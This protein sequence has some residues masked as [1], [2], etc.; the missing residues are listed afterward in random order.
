MTKSKY[1][2]KNITLLNILLMGAIILTGHYSVLP[3]L[4]IN[5][6]YTLPPLKK[7]T[8]EEEMMTSA[9]NTPSPS[10]YLII[11]EENL[12]HPERRIPP[13]KKVEQELPKPEFILYGILISDDLSI[14]YLEDLK[15][16][17]TT[18]G[19]GKRQ[20]AVKKGDTFSGFT[21]KDV[22]MDKV[23]MLRGE[24][25]LVVPLVDP[26][27]PKSRAAI[28]PLTQKSPPSAPQPPK[29]P[30]ST[31]DLLKEGPPTKTRAPMTPADEQARDFFLRNK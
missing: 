18:P 10:D 23:V 28:A 29:Q 4:N 17:R 16:P 25:K 12:F 15:A 20:A 5:S 21:L 14:A 6:T 30:M 13:E 9:F 8:G 26:Q 19:R 3:L 27:R 31:K 1:F 7:M 22:E 24:E 11:S 2:F